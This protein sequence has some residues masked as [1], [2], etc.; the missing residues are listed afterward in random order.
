MLRYA[1]NEQKV[2]NLFKGTFE[3]FSELYVVCHIKFFTIICNN[4]FIGLIIFSIHL[5]VLNS[6]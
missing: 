1:T 5:A 4:K 6:L 2:Q 3:K